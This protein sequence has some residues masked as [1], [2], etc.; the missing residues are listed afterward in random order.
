MPLTAGQVSLLL[1]RLFH[2][3]VFRG[4]VCGVPLALGTT[5]IFQKVLEVM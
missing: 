1:R 2:L 5:A 4:A 3:Q